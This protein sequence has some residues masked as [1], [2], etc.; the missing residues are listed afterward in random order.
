MLCSWPKHA[1]SRHV[2]SLLWSVPPLQLQLHAPPGCVQQWLFLGS[3][4]IKLVFSQNFACCCCI[5]LLVCQLWA[6]DDQASLLLPIAVSL[7]MT[8]TLGCGSC[9]TLPRPRLQ[10]RGSEMSW[11]PPLPVAHLL[12]F[13]AEPMQLICWLCSSQFV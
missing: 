2:V 9:L 6:Q 11:L 5:R 12:S 7:V 4:S 10:W 13:L 1:S 8:P 3:T